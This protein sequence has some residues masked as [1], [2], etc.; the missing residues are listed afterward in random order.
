MIPRMLGILIAMHAAEL[1]ID[2]YPYW[3]RWGVIWRIGA[4]LYGLGLVL[5]CVRYFV[6]RRANPR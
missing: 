3:G 6:E 2:L 5:S 4:A 1:V